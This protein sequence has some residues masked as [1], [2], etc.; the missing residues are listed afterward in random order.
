MVNLV[1]NIFLNIE[2]LFQ[3]VSSCIPNNVVSGCN[4]IYIAGM[5]EA[6]P[7][8]VVDTVETLELFDEVIGM[9]V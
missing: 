7:S 9:R 2:M 1:Y 6:P 5:S 4:T 3:L 8:E